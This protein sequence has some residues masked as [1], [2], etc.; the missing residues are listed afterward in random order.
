MPRCNALLVGAALV[1]LTGVSTAHA[2]ILASDSFNIPSYTAGGLNG[3]T[4]GGTGFKG[5]WATSVG[6][7]LSIVSPG[8]LGRPVVAGG[9]AG[10]R[11]LFAN[12]GFLVSSGQIFISYDINSSALLNSSRLGLIVSTGTC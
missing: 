8:L 5:A 1:C 2:D 3:Q 10:D 11:A 6:Q 4:V 9:N 7:D 12:I